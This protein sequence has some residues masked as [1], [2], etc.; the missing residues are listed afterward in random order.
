MKVVFLWPGDNWLALICF[1]PTVY[2][3]GHMS[4]DCQRPG[5]GLPPVTG[6]QLTAFHRKLVECLWPYVGWLSMATGQLV[7]WLALGKMLVCCLLPAESCL[8]I[9]RC[10]LTVSR[11]N[12]CQLTV[13]GRMWVDFLWPNFSWLP[14][15]G[16]QLWAD[17]ICRDVS[18]RP[19]IGWPMTAYDRMWADGLCQ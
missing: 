3:C 16:C 1:H 2:D 4:S 19:T 6:C 18:W 14:R 17:L 8:P 11:L 12:P 7:N 5:V 9:I 10:Q 13:F 15:T